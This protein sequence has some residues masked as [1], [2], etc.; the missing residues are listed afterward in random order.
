MYITSKKCRAIFIALL[1]SPPHIHPG[2][3]STAPALYTFVVF[4]HKTIARERRTERIGKAAITV[5]HYIILCDIIIWVAFINVYIYIYI[6]MLVSKCKDAN[7]TKCRGHR[8]CIYLYI[9][10][11]GFIGR[12]FSS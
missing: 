1:S 4:N 2:Q 12:L 7:R 3:F 9:Y 11:I 10:Y 5:I 8:L 6:F